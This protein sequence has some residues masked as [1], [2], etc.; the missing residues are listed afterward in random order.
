MRDAR[1][2]LVMMD[3]TTMTQALGLSLY[4]PRMAAILLAV[5]G[6]LALVL[7]GIGLYGVVSYAVSRRTR[8]VGIRMS[9]GADA[10]QVVRMVVGG[11]MRLVILGG[12]LG[13]GLSA[14]VTWLLS[15]FL[16]GVSTVALATFVAIPVLLT[17]VAALAAFVPARRA[18]RV[19]P[20]EALRTE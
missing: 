6:G 10:R 17:V 18:S 9:L 19:N 14:T 7:S 2:D 15:R 1:S 3:A 20:V 12:I 11:G 4:A 5:F 13:M 8:E 16:Y